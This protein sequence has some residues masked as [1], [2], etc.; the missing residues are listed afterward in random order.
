MDFTIWIWTSCFKFKYCI[1]LYFN[2]KSVFHS[3]LWTQTYL[4][5][6]WCPH[7]SLLNVG[8]TNISS[9]ATK[10]KFFACWLTVLLEIELNTGLLSSKV[11]RMV[12]P[13]LLEPMKENHNKILFVLV[14]L[15]ML[16]WNF[17]KF[18]LCHTGPYQAYFTFVTLKY[19][20]T[21]SLT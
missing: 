21:L 11:P 10:N 15:D 4:C 14:Q 7:I 2:S 18:W 17:A 1:E 9:L 8:R 19:A 20:S 13:N 5:M 12:L 6:F 3:L 16:I